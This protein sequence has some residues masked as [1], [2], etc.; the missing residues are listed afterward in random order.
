M[1]RLVESQF[2]LTIQV[3]ATD[4]EGDPLQY[5]WS[6]SSSAIT[7]PSNLTTTTFQVISNP[8]VGIYNIAI[9][10]SDGQQRSTVSRAL[11]VLPA[12]V[13][14]AADSDGDGRSNTI[15]AARD[16]DGDG[17]PDLFDDDAIP[18]YLLPINAALNQFITA[19]PGVLLKPGNL[20]IAESGL[21]VI[22]AGSADFAAGVAP[23]AEDA[24]GNVLPADSLD[25]QDLAIVD[26]IAT[27][28]AFPG[29]QIQVAIPIIGNL[30]ADPVYRKYFATPHGGF[31]GPQ[32][33]GRL[34][35]QHDRRGCR[36]RHGGLGFG[37][38]SGHLSQR[39]C[40]GLAINALCRRYRQC[41]SPTRH[42]RWR[43]K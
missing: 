19:T 28:L 1:A 3:L 2:P 37:V 36:R 4:P 14:S 29:A 41:L 12:A 25:H 27:N 23:G 26:F 9:E 6:G 22:N 43:S 10:L 7:T 13:L 35:H 21:Q 15:E 24:S 34:R 42:Y 33:L 31:A 5:D 38:G 16:R 11:L 18:N 32:W 8:G 17:T 30:P 40:I 39:P 20:A